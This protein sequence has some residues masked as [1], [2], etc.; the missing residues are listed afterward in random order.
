MKFIPVLLSFIGT[1]LL[2]FI[3]FVCNCR[4]YC[5]NFGGSGSIL[6]LI[7][8]RTLHAQTG[9]SVSINSIEG[10]ERTTPQFRTTRSMLIP[11]SRNAS[12]RAT[13]TC[14]GIERKQFTVQS[15]ELSS[16]VSLNGI[17]CQPVALPCRNSDK[18]RRV[19]TLRRSTVRKIAAD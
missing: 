4:R 7:N 9:G 5:I 2:S 10:K 6:V 12:A 19:H 13:F 8:I 16:M 15:I 3:S 17:A 11:L 18:R 14:T 1:D